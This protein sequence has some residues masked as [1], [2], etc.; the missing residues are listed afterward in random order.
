MSKKLKQKLINSIRS[1]RQK[2]VVSTSQEDSMPTNSQETH[3]QS[4]YPLTEEC[5]SRSTVPKRIKLQ[6]DNQNIDHDAQAL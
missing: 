2:N 6:E 4:T 1:K 3:S 5:D